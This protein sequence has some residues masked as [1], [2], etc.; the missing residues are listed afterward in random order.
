MKGRPV[1]GVP[2]VQAIATYPLEGCSHVLSIRVQSDP[3]LHHFRFPTGQ[4]RGFSG[5][6]FPGNFIVTPDAE[7]ERFAKRKTGQY[8]AVWIEDLRLPW[9]AGGGEGGRPK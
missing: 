8:G 2:G 9:G 4:F 5:R 6:F 3:G 1:L 7:T